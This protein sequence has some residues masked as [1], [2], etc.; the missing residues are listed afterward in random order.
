MKFR[1]LARNYEHMI[2]VQHFDGTI[3]KH[4]G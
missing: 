2:G 3:K 4:K 1:S